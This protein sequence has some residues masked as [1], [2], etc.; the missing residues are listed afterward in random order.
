MTDK[1]P[2]DVAKELGIQASTLRK[3]SLLF[4]KE[5][6]IFKRHANNM[7]IYTDM[8]VVALHEFITL[9]RDGSETLEN[10]VK[11]ASDKLKGVSTITVENGVTETPTQR[12]D[13]DI[14][15]VMLAEIRSLRQEIKDRDALFVEALEKMQE[16][17]DRMEEQQQQ[18]LAP[19]LD[20]E[21]DVVTTDSIEKDANSN[22]PLERDVTSNDTPEDDVISNHPIEKDVVST[23]TPDVTSNDSRKKKG[24]FARIFGK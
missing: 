15:T 5:G 2:H 7:R 22:R 13:D 17:I 1:T 14:A 23:D 24:F 20:P 19:V 10:A 18:L 12:Y 16:K 21:D 11:I 6:I 9:T 4:E 8:E 3:Y